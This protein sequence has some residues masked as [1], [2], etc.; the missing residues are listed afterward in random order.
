MRIAG[1]DIPDKKEA[2]SPLLTSTVLAVVPHK[3]F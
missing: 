3:K 2:K 1:V